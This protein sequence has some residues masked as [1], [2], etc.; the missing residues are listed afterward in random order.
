MIL[1]RAIPSS[2][3][4]TIL[5]ACVGA[6]FGVIL[7]CATVWLSRRHR[8]RQRHRGQSAVV[9]ASESGHTTARSKPGISD[10]INLGRYLAENPYPLPQQV[11]QKP[12]PSTPNPRTRQYP[13]ITISK[14][15][16]PP[17]RDSL[18]MKLT[19]THLEFI[20]RA[21]MR[22]RLAALSHSGIH[23]VSSN[24]T[25]HSNQAVA[26]SNLLHPFS[27]VPNPHREWPKEILDLNNSA[28]TDTSDGDISHAGLPIND[29]FKA[30]QEIKAQRGALNGQPRT[31]SQMILD[32][33]TS[34]EIGEEGPGSRYGYRGGW[35][36]GGSAVR[37]TGT[38]EDGAGRGGRA[39]TAWDEQ[40]VVPEPLHIEKMEG[41][42]LNSGPARKW[43]R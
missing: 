7:V 8:S 23:P 42:H 28:T 43:G 36:G 41:A 29:A 15:S 30:L 38:R 19:N 9:A 22:D 3:I 2:T 25:N 16:P 4:I 1:R 34:T 18:G 31:I 17:R 20:N 12:S 35:G 10:P 40:R 13:E 32:S 39:D 11:L 24:N 5:C 27:S 33:E 6:L 37:Y 21:D 26:S 14:S